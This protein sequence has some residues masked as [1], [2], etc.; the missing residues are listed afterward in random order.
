M[1]MPNQRDTEKRKDKKAAE[2]IIQSALVNMSFSSVATLWPFAAP[3]SL[4][5]A[6]NDL[7]PE[8]IRGKILRILI[9]RQIGL[10]FLLPG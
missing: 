2:R 8:T 3:T 6:Q 1:P 4:T 9:C 10:L 5:I 7:T